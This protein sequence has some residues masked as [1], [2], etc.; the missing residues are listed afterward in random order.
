MEAERLAVVERNQG[1]LRMLRAGFERE[2]HPREIEGPHM[3]FPE[4][5]LFRE[6]ARLLAC[7]AEALAGEGQYGRAVQATIDGMR[8]ARDTCEGG[9]LIH[10]LVAIAIEAIVS[11]EL[12]TSLPNMAP[13]DALAAATR[14]A[15]L[16]QAE[17]PLAET[18]EG[19]RAMLRIG[20]EKAMEQ[21]DGVKQLVQMV[22]GQWR[23]GK[24]NIA[25]SVQA[26]ETFFQRAIE[27]LNA[28]YHQREP[29]PA[30]EDRLAEMM[31]PALDRVWWKAA[32]A[33][34]RRRLA[35]VALALQAYRGK[36]GEYPERLDGLTP[37]ILAELPADPFHDGPPFYRRDGEGYRLYSAGPDC[38]D[39]GG[40]RPLPRAHGP[41]DDGDLVWGVEPERKREH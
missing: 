31:V 6:L 36:H 5:G 24:P 34:A 18:F 29:V 4:F 32:E 2:Y 25:A 13:G 10:R 17:V 28:P 41:D 39:D 27:A 26:A 16:D 8:L 15:A 14:L 23:G 1:A 22:G 19:D 21:P 37:E 11:Q 9:T 40:N 20:L 35:V 38:D 3:V 12:E 30:P 33:Q 7:E